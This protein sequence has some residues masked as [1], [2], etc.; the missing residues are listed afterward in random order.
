MAPETVFSICNM[1]AMLGWIILIV[2]PGWYAADKFIIGII[3]TL[4]ALIYAWMLFSDFKLEDAAKFGSLQGVMELFKNPS[5]VTAG[6]VHYLAFD[7]LAGLFI[8]TNARTHGISHWLVIPCLLLTFM[9]GPVGLLLYLLIRW[10]VT[11]YYF[12][13][14]F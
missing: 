7:L 5:L 6:W 9:F 14:N 11:K 13:D 8:R 4:F 1:I 10:A 3:I 12:A 2:L